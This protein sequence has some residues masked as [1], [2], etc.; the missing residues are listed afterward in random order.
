MKCVLIIV[1]QLDIYDYIGF[2][3]SIKTGDSEL[4]ATCTGIALT[5]ACVDYNVSYFHDD[6]Y[7]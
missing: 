7:A 4:E 1:A 6:K 2:F 5:S 3:N